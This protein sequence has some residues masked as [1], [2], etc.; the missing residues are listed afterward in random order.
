MPKI[1]Q[2][3]KRKTYINEIID[4][5]IIDGDSLKVTLDLGYG[6]YKGVTVRLDRLDA[7]EL[8]SSNPLEREA[9]KSVT[10]VSRRIM[11]ICSDQMMVLESQQLDLYGRA[12]GDIF[13]HKCHVELNS[14][15]I[16]LKIARRCSGDKARE[17]WR[18]EELKEIIDISHKFLM[19]LDTINPGDTLYDWIAK[20]SYLAGYLDARMDGYPGM[21][22]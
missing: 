22:C 20:S 3:S 4:Y 5:E 19:Q 10:L 16:N 6:C 13:F 8:K 15:L 2:K 1:L 9:A 21:E 14:I 17:P 18:D 11:Q 7:P 12:V